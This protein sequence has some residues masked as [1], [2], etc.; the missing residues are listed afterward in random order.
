MFYISITMAHETLTNGV[1]QCTTAL[2]DINRKRMTWGLD[3]YEGAK[4]SAKFFARKRG[5]CFLNVDADIPQDECT[6]VQV[7]YDSNLAK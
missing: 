4:A 2:C 1:Q 7:G 5:Y 6:Y 3:D